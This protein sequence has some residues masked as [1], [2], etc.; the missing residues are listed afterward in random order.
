MVCRVHE[1]LLQRSR[2]DF[3]RRHQYS[4]LCMSSFPSVIQ[5]EPANSCNLNCPMCLHSTWSE[6]TV[7][8]APAHFLSLARE[9]FP[10]LK[11]LVLYGWGEPLTHPD[12]L[13]ILRISKK[14]L[15]S[16]A[17]VFFTTNGSLL[18]PEL[19]SCLICEDLIQ[20]I[21]V[22]C[23]AISRTRDSAFGHKSSIPS[24]LSN[25][26]YL[27]NNRLGA[28]PA[29]G[30]ETTVMRSN[31]RSL[32]LLIEELCG[33]G[34]DYISVSHIYP[35]SNVTEDEMLYTLISAEALSVLDRLGE[36]GL[37]IISENSHSILSIE[38]SRT[39]E[40]TGELKKYRKMLNDAAKNNI[41]L[42]IALYKKVLK[43]LPLLHE[44]Q[45]VFSQAEEIACSAGIALTL[46]PVFAS[47]NNRKCPYIESS[48]A[49]IRS[50]GEV[51]PC[52]KYL[53]PHS[54]FLSNHTSVFPA[55][56]F[57][58]IKTR[59][60]SEIW[61]SERYSAFRSNMKEMNEHIAWCGDCKFSSMN[62]FFTK[63]NISDC[64][65]NSPFCSECPYSLNLTRCLL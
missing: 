62:C 10:H 28:S 21:A 46:P 57:G 4:R 12:F 31:F 9:V 6:P 53:Y 2:S 37:R 44:V 15:P 14:W 20:D 61:N 1:K 51:A 29:I 33:S 49:V 65:T 26:E 39:T 27:L 23:D 56:S 11:R 63:N 42:N 64:L 16:S 22:S 19:S 54:S 30:V 3:L 32:P 34:I 41:K 35:Y 17:S 36:H 7:Q 18:T 60:F 45:K 24:V 47:I 38:H 43:K 8:M 25:L 40:N 5:I 52:F 13:D 59:K 50:D 48:A 58:N 55:Y